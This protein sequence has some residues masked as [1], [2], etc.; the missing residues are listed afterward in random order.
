LSIQSRPY[1]ENCTL[2]IIKPHAV[3]NKNV[4]QIIDA[5]LSA[6]FE[7][8]S[9]QMILFDHA[10]AQEFYE[11]YKFLPEQKKLI[12]HL[13]SGPAVALEVRQD[14]V[15]EKFRKLC[16]PYDPEIARKL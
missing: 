9:M 15:V 3:K 13:S 14:N 8:S 12:D 4:G 11:A 5:I 7:I 16:G 6:G 1:Y 10:V 2:C